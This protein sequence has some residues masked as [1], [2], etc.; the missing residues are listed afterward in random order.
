MQKEDT[1][2]IRRNNL[3]MLIAQHTQAQM[4]AGEG[5]MGAE[6]SFATKLQVSKSLLSQLKS[7]RN[8]SDAMA[9]QIERACKKPLGWLSV[10]HQ[11]DG[12]S[13]EVF[14]QALKQWWLHSTVE[15]RREVMLLLT[16]KKARKTSAKS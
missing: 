7:S 16:K 10:A 9:I 1:H 8:I 5:H 4:A 3:R 12:D 2:S 15:E 13:L 14:T 11:D 6:T